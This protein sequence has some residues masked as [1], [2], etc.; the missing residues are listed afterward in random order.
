MNTNEINSKGFYDDPKITHERK[1]SQ[2]LKEQLAILFTQQLQKNELIKNLKT[3]LERLEKIHDHEQVKSGIGRLIRR[4]DFDKSLENNWDQFSIYF[5][6]A[7]QNFLKRLAKKH[8]KLSPKD[9]KLCAYL[10]LNLS[11]KDI[12]PLLNISV[13]GVEIS[14]YRLRKKLGLNNKENLVQYLGGL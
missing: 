10:R 6:S 12:A 14:R 5:D 2:R 11:T 1:E 4:I 13:R 8:P 7:N 3:E 9:H